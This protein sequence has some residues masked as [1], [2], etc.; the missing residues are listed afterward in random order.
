MFVAEREGRPLKLRAFKSLSSHIDPEAVIQPGAG[1][2]G[3]AHKTGRV[4]NV[5]QVSFETERLLFYTR[6][7]EIKS[8][9]A[10]P[11]PEIA[12]VL[13]MDSKRRYIFTEKS[14]KLFMQF[15]QSIARLWRRLAGPPARRKK[16]GAPG[17]K[18]GG[19]PE[20][21][22]SEVCALW[23]G[24]EF[25]LSR[26]DNEGGG[27]AAA[28]EQ[29]RGFAGLTWAFMTVLKASDKKHYYLAAASVNTPESLAGKYLLSSGLAGWLHTKLKPLTIDRLRTD[30]RN[31]YIFHQHE[32]LRGFRSFYGWPIL[33]NDQPRGAMILAGAEGEVMD[34]GLME[35]MDCVVDRLAA[36]LHLD[37]LIAKVLEMDLM[38][39]Q[40]ALPY[41]GPF[42]DSLRQMTRVADIKGEGVDLYVLA[43][44]GLGALAVSHGQE[45]AADLLRAVAARLGD[46]L[47]PT[48]R[49]GHVSY[50][51]FTLA[52]PSADS[53]EAK[54]F[55]YNFKKS[56]E[57]W[58]LPGAVGRAGLGLFLAL[59]AY[60]RDG[61]GPEELLEAAL[62]ALAE[63][64]EGNP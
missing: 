8:F 48:W 60:P 42:L 17:G 53:A 49:L 18:D 44:S 38:D 46:G 39:A 11:L 50:G 64:E 3:W 7:E 29:V 37:R 1:L 2:L 6:D 26:S 62:N 61:T 31:S 9:M 52:T 16:G 59:A 51:V 28:L 57:N 34:H 22:V 33:Y 47:R 36:Q 10:V 41:R 14:A 24:L 56:L 30:G 40:T 13:A 55:I 54:S 15:S 63:G 19:Q 32:P 12:A 25:C 23:Q 4:V 5:D 45:T 20:S 43:T 27:L 21:P 58:P 35:V